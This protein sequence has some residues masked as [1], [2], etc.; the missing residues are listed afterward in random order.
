MLLR[1]LEVVN[2]R[3]IKGRLVAPLDAKI[4]LLHGENGAGKTSLLSAIGLALTGQVLSLARADP[5]YQS[6]LLHWSAT[7]GRIELGT[8]DGAFFETLLTSSDAS[9][10]TILLSDRIASFFSERCYLPQ[11]LLGQ[12]LSIYQASSEDIDSPLARFVGE[13]LG[14]DRLDALDAGLNPL[15]DLRNVRKIAESYSG[16][17]AEKTRRERVLADNR[18]NLETTEKALADALGKLAAARAK[19]DLGGSVD[20]DSLKFNE[21]EL[22]SSSDEESI[23][24]LADQRRQLDAIQR[25][26]RRNQTALAQ[27]DESTLAANHTQTLQALKSWQKNDQTR[28]A[29]VRKRAEALLP[30]ADLPAS[31][32]AFHEEATRLLRAE[33]QQI[34]DRLTRATQASERQAAATR[35]LEVARKQLR[36]SMMR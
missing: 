16:V 2:F 30:S 36:T 1:E 33:R 18:R 29:A 13:L 14:L 21:A 9:T 8:D 7:E 6:Q 35:E 5:A 12:L 25:E 32:Q 28:I 4:V 24:Q 27:S 23:V 26:A 10:K 20:E 3:S 22:S 19:L 11:S 15:A 17:E 34:S 31:L